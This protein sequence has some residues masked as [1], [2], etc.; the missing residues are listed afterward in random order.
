MLVFF[1]FCAGHD[2]NSTA[3]LNI[4]MIYYHETRLSEKVY[5]TPPDKKIWAQAAD[6]NPGEEAAAAAWL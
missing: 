4:Y 3:P 2:C 1:L 6:K 5:T